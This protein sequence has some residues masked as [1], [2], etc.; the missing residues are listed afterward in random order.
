MR[1]EWPSSLLAAD[2]LDAAEAF[3]RSVHGFAKRLP[4]GERAR[5]VMALDS[6][7]YSQQGEA[8]AELCAGLHP[9]HRLTRYHEFFASRVR[10]DER[11]LDLGCGN[12]ALSISIAKAGARVT[13]MDLSEKSL[14][15]AR[16]AA[17]QTALTHAPAFVKGDI[18]TDRVPGEFDTIVMSNV[19]EHVDERPA[20]LRGWRSW[21]GSPRFLIRVPAFDRDW[22][23]P[24]KRELGVEWRLDLTH[25]IEYTRDELTRELS[26][27]GLEVT[28][29]ASA[30]GEYWCEARPR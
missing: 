12:G 7:L 19:L 2:V 21:Y 5:F 8:A 24:W 1:V 3:A 20:R 14:A 22:R 17:E 11:V 6:A 30:W 10:R 9:K 25:E 16:L 15:R 26:A 4:V 23:V 27:A 28:E 13:G 18:T 29:L